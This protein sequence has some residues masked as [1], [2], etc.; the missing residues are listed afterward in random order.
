MRPTSGTGTD[1][2]GA[3]PAPGR[4][5]PAKRIAG[6]TLVEILV[7]V[8]IVGLVVA[9]ASVNLT[10]GDREV[11]RRES[12]RLALAIESARDTAW[13]GG[14]PVALTFHENRLRRLAR[15]GNGWRADPARDTTVP[16]D[17][18]IAAVSV[19]G[20][21][22]APGEGLVFLPD[23]LDEPF[24]V[25]LEVRGRGWAVDGDAAGA[26]TVVER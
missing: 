10:P 20:R 23:G 25:A 21:A 11:G 3:R 2:T 6:F 9:I 5:P 24:R 18:R 17:V 1:R 26:I 7:V 12:A 13:F 15:V 22:L 8:A 14:R 4:R 16:G 19:N